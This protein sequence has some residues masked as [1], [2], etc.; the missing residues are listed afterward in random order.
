MKEA[1]EPVTVRVT[2]QMID[3]A[4]RQSTSQCAIALALRDADDY[5]SH[6]SV[7][8]KEIRVTDHRTGQRYVFKTPPALA[9]WVDKFDRG[10]PVKPVTFALDLSQ[11]DAVRE[12]HRTSVRALVNQARRDRERKVMP[13]RETP[14]PRSQRPL[15]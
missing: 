4:L 9:R 8:Q 1:E 5:F 11:A 6:P 12:V 15:R 14:I 13:A 7:N 10:E 3:W 2:K